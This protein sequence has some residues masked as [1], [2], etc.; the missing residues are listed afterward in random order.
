MG[1]VGAD[2]RLL[3]TCPSFLCQVDCGGEEHA[4][5]PL[6][7]TKQCFVDAYQVC[8]RGE[9]VSIMP[10]FGP[11]DLEAGKYCRLAA[12]ACLAHEIIKDN[13][14]DLSDLDQ[15]HWL[16]FKIFC[17]RDSPPSAEL[18]PDADRAPLRGSPSE[19][20]RSIVPLY[21]EDAESDC[22]PGVWPF[23]IQP[24]LNSFG[25]PR[26]AHAGRATPEGQDTWPDQ[27]PGQRAGQ[28]RRIAVNNGTKRDTCGHS[29]ISAVS[30][31]ISVPIR[32]V[33]CTPDPPVTAGDF[34][35]ANGRLVTAPPIF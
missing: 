28:R 32:F 3:V 16:A 9:A 13:D 4:T 11:V 21:N 2:S 17:Y 25:S 19:C 20:S 18:G 22:S 31:P 12:L 5:R 33:T 15:Q 7:S 24:G 1:A 10:Q 14:D 6:S 27:P 29:A 34:G 23:D 26:K 8:A 30:T 35:D